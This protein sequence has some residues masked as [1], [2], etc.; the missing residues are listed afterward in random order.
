MPCSLYIDLR[1][2]FAFVAAVELVYMRHNYITA[3]LSLI[4]LISLLLLHHRKG[5]SIRPMSNI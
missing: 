5:S 3:N 4:G 2:I 1:T